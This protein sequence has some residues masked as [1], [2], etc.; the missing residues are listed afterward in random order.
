MAGA[1][2]SV[3]SSAARPSWNASAAALELQYPTMCGM[4]TA[5]A[6]EAMV[7]T[8]PWLAAIMEGSTARAS[9]KCESVLTAK[10][11]SMV[12]SGAVRN[13]PVGAMPALLIRIVGEP[14]RARIWS[15]ARV[16]LEAEV[17]SQ[18]KWWM[19]EALWYCIEG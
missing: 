18:A 11:R 3:L 17:M 19:F 7:T 14:K 9:W 4:L 16:M 12:P 1:S 10:M 5:A 13:G 2:Y 8:V 6:S 15:R